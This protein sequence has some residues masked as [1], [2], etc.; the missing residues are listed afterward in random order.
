MTF[1]ERNL[2]DWRKVIDGT[3]NE[4]PKATEWFDNNEIVSI[5]NKL[6]AVPQLCH[7]FYPSSGGMLIKGARFSCE[8]GC[9]ELVTDGGADIVKPQ[10]LSFHYFGESNYEWAYFRLETGELVPSGVYKNYDD[11]FRYEEVTELRPGKYVARSHYDAG[12]YGYDEHGEKALP[13]EARVVS[14]IFN[15]SF[16]F[17]AT[18]SI[19]NRTSSTYDGRHNKMTS[20]Q[21]EDHIKSALYYFSQKNKVIED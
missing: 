7:M 9:I 15:G 16:V 5:L 13:S 10:K 4:M 18:A 14:R 6:G 20:E 21:F 8:P 3:F 2:S 1:E 12:F 17:F 19:Y 11:D